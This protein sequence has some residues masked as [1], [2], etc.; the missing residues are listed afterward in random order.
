MRAAET[1]GTAQFAG[2]TLDDGLRWGVAAVLVVGLGAGGLR[3]ARDYMPVQTAPGLADPVMLIDLAPPAPPEPAEPLPPV[4]PT[5]PM[6]EPA[7]PD[8]PEALPEEVDEAVPVSA[9]PL[10]EAIDGAKPTP[11]PTA[12]EIPEP[13]PEPEPVPAVA[14]EPVIA[15]PLAEVTLPAVPLPVRISSALQAQRARTAPTSRS[16]R[17]ERVS[18][19]SQRET[20][21]PAAAQAA[22]AQ[23]QPSG[24]A[25]ANWQSG[26]LQQLD[27]AKVYPPSAQQAREEGVVQISFSVDAHGRLSDIRVMR[28]SGSAT[29]DQAAIATAQRASPVQAPP[30][31]TDNGMLSLAAAIRFALR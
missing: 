19:K 20:A 28:S 29:L 4:A 12:A 13:E 3:L 24:R 7:V 27:R 22:A 5:K 9:P 14:P 2:L 31:G 21:R 11:L 30:A 25:V 18:P 6:E 23:P 16:P 17:P 15:P 10:P 8:E 1:I 26:V